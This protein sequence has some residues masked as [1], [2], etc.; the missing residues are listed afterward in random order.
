MDYVCE[1]SVKP[2]ALHKTSA[3]TSKLWNF[4]MLNLCSFHFHFVAIILHL[5]VGVAEF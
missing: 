2:K 5:V 3:P 4:F 1:M